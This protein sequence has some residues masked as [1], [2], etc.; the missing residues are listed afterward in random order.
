MNEQGD[1]RRLPERQRL[2]VFD[3][4]MEIEIILPP[5]AEPC[6][7]IR[8][9][10]LIPPPS[11]VSHEKPD[12]KGC[13]EEV[14][15]LEEGWNGPP[16]A[17]FLLTRESKIY[18]PQAELV[19]LFNPDWEGKVIM[20]DGANRLETC[21]TVG[22]E[23]LVPLQIFPYSHPDMVLDTE[24]KPKWW[25]LLTKDEV[26]QRALSQNLAKPKQTIHLVNIKGELHPVRHIQPHLRISR[27]GIFGADFV[28]SI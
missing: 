9:I 26:V 1:Q 24:K 18:E 11:V 3:R 12:P 19:E 22:R 28:R 6:P 2:R 16:L 25:N 14:T 10:V 27:E 17:G 20:I 7:F 5:L 4:E 23:T 13:R 15:I 21:L 8:H